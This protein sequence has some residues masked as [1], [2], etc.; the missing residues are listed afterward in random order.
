MIRVRHS[1]LFITI[2]SALLLIFGTVAAQD[3]MG[4]N[5]QLE[6][7]ELA[8]MTWE[9]IVAAADGGTV[10]WF[11]WGGSD[12][13]NAYVSEWVGS[14]LQEEYNITLNR[15][16]I[17]NTVDAVNQVLGEAEA[18]QDDNGS[19]DMIWINGENFR[20]M[21]QGGLLYCGYLDLL[22]NMQYIDQ[23]DPTIAFDFG[24]PVDGCEVAWG[25]AQ[26]ALIYNSDFVEEPPA[27]MD[28]LLEWVCENPGSFTYPAPPDFTGSV[29]VRHVF[30]NEANKIYADEG[31]YEKLLGEFDEEVYAPVAEATWATLNEIEPCLWR[32]G[33]LYPRD[34]PAL[35]QLYANTEVTFN[36]TYEPSQA[37]VL[38][39]NGT[40]PPSTQTYALQSGTIGNVHYVAIPFNSPNKAAAL[41]L[42]NLLISPEAQ[43]EKNRPD[44]WGVTTVLDQM[45]MPEDFQT[46]F[47]E[48]PRHPA[49]V[50]REELAEVALPEL[51]SEWLVRIEQDWEANVAQR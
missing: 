19:V 34:K 14:R 24:T 47:S 2:I 9:E 29:F 32:E 5:L 3:D 22:P 33:E 40:F 49:V 20:T 8:G 1:A 4:Q 46:A 11:M 15:V 17:T 48:L 18:G 41:V 43:L 21:K 39:D 7:S 26:V 36:V 31:G 23:D 37:G 25:R 28:A 6:D 35:D 30:Y 45:A 51:Q 12:I 42:A 38:I 16:G 50:S 13:I 27:D 10:N 44:V